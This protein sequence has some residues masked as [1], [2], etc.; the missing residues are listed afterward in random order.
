MI[1]TLQALNNNKK[2][3]LQIFIKSKQ[4]T[5]KKKEPNWNF[6]RSY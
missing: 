6:F 3:A 2:T 4:K 5:I 1:K